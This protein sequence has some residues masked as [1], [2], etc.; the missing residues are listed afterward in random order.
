MTIEQYVL[1]GGLI[2]TWIGAAISIYNVRLTRRNLAAQTENVEAQST[3]EDAKASESYANAS[4]LV[5][6]ELVTVRTRLAE[7]NNILDGRDKLIFQLQGDK[8]DL[9]DWAER[10]VH[11]VQS[12]AAEPVPFRSS[13]STKK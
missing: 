13:R 8:A 10:L 7:L 12:L 3:S 9:Q 11:Q 2:V 5:A 1:L 6:D 4:R